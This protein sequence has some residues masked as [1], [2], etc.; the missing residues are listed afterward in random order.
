MPG[1]TI[2]TA[3]YNAL[4]GLRRTVES[5]A[6][7]DQHGVQHVIVDGGSTDG[8][9]AYLESLGDA[10]VWIS[11]PDEGIA[12]A[13]NKGV[14]LAGGDYILF[15][16][17]EDEFLSTSS[18]AK[19]AAAMGDA[20]VVS[21]D[22]RVTM[23]DEAIIYRTAGFGPMLEFFMTVPHQGAFCRKTLF[24][25]IGGFDPKIRVAMDYDFMLR[26]KRAGASI[27]AVNEPISIMPFTGVSARRDWPSVKARIAENRRVQQ[28]HRRKGPAAALVMHA[29]WIFYPI[30]KWLRT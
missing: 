27:V 14:G 8:T 13:M 4:D 21:F 26:A 6:A 29:F 3:T 28:R 1:I 15:L 18:L 12:D 11:E 10:V 19:A 30:F 22:V 25:R 5:V 23:G 17:A 7:Q 24:E 2:V 9:R 16:H 20:D